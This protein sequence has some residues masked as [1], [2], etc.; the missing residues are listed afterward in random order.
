MR[1]IGLE[2]REIPLAASQ[3][4][5]DA[6][7]MLIER[8]VSLGRRDKDV[9]D[10]LGISVLPALETLCIYHSNQEALTRACT[11]LHSLIYEPPQNHIAA[12]FGLGQREKTELSS[13][14]SKRRILHGLEDGDVRLIE[15]AVGKLSI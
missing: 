12:Q 4:A 7:V 13:Y 6:A 2:P 1:L 14:A 3:K 5:V 11:R 15:N 10:K 8:S 9:T